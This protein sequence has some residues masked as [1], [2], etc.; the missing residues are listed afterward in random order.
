[1]DETKLFFD[2]TDILEVDELVFAVGFK[3]EARIAIGICIP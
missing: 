2:E 3:D 1:M